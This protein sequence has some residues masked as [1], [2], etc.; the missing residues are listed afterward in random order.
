M[1]KVIEDLTFR[2]AV[3]VEAPD[4][5][6]QELATVFRAVPIATLRAYDR[7]EIETDELL[8]LIVVDFEDLADASG[9]PV[10]GPEWRR[11]LL[12]LPWVQTALY[13]AY[14]PAVSGARAGNSAPSAGT[15]QPA[16]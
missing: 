6:V 12:D 2:R 13:R 4:G 15:G 3:P 9:E 1:F 7:Q 11:K 16:G 10:S 5:R 14:L 8:E